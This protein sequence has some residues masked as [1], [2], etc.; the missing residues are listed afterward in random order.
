[1]FQYQL[2]YTSCEF[3]ADA[4]C[5]TGKLFLV[6]LYRILKIHDQVSGI[7]ILYLVLFS[8]LHRFISFTVDVMDCIG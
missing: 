5:R 1:M 3:Y 4:I 6:T 2:W 8:Y 7:L